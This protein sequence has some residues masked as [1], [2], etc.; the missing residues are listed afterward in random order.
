MIARL[1]DWYFGRLDHINYDSEWS[2]LHF[3]FWFIVIPS[4]TLCVILGIIGSII[5]IATGPHP[6]PFNCYC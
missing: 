2:W 6:P 3:W 5:I 4:V 1:F